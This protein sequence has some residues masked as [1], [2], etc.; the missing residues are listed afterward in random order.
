MCFILDVRCIDG[1]SVEFIYTASGINNYFK[2]LYYKRLDVF[3]TIL[4]IR[5]FD[6]KRLMKISSTNLF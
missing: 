6:S 4:Y 1:V 3:L 5:F 2:V